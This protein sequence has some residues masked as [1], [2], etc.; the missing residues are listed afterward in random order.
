[1]E[2]YK[3]SILVITEGEEKELKCVARNAFPAPSFT[4]TGPPQDQ[5]ATDFVLDLASQ[6]NLCWY[7]NTI[8][9]CGV[10]TDP[11]IAA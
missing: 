3:D 10:S 7:Y 2:S 9:Q 5:G 8:N 1:M 11:N 4:W 6:V